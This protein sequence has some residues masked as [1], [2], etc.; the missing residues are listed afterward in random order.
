M[1]NILIGLFSFS[2]LS[3]ASYLDYIYDDRSAT[4][5]S[6]GQT[7]LIQTPSAETKGENGVY[8]VL[9]KND[10]YK[11]ATL[12]V[13]PFDWME[14]SYFYYQPRDFIWGGLKGKYLDKGFNVKINYKPGVRYLPDNIALGLDDF[15]GT[16]FFSREYIA[17]TYD[18]DWFKLSLGLG[19]GKYATD[20]SYKNPF[21]KIIS[22]LEN[23]PNPNLDIWEVG[24]PSFNQWFRGD[25]GLFGGIEAFIPRA[26]GL[27]FKIER[28]PFDYFDFSANFRSDSSPILRK[29]ESDINFG[30]SYP[31][32]DFITSEISFIKGNSINVSFVVGKTFKKSKRKKNFK[33]IVEKRY[34]D[35]DM[36]KEFYNNLLYNLNKDKLFLQ[37]ADLKKGHLN[38]S[39][40]DDNFNNAIVASSRAAYYAKQTAKLSSIQLNQIS[41]SGIL[42]GQEVYKVN[43]DANDINVPNKLPGSVIK[44]RII[45]NDPSSNEDYIN[46]EFQPLVKFPVFFNSIE[47][48]FRTHVG[49]PERFIYEGLG[50]S[51]QSEIQLSRSLILN[52][53]LGHSFDDDFDEKNPRPASD[54]PHVRTEIISY[55][56]ATDNYI[57]SAKFDYFWN[58]KPEMFFKLS[59]G[60]FEM[61]YAGYGLEYL[62]KPFEKNFLVGF[63]IYDVKRRTFEQKFEL[64]DYRVQTGHINFAYY[65]ENSG[66]TFKTSY[67]RYLAKDSGFTF[68]LSRK[69]NN[70][71]EAGFYFTLTDVPAELFGEGSFDKGFYFEIPFDLFQSKYSKNTFPFAYKPLTRDGGQ[72]LI[73][74]NDLISIYQDL[75]K[76]KIL[77]GSNEFLD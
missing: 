28:D 74:S 1:K 20:K 19:W 30:F 75:T 42:L 36:K 43:Y 59:G 49:S 51:F 67:G 63:E 54:L 7:G 29:K 24:R 3:E 52:L 48:D 64:L 2:I 40:D 66:I 37:T 73:N 5:N 32:N 60:I 65:F 9:N 13:S 33:P 61:M 35:P 14:A 17:G 46:H 26:R 71:F 39:I 69:S 45:I 44:Q 38:I 55:L 68:D 31:I 58:P 47:P 23:R 34:E 11:F 76:T 12:T 6:F 10:I 21:S 53:N 4:Y 16:G 56:Q 15:A 62:Y 72:K 18:F 77:E 25:I 27:K 57:T 50:L 70:G 22:Q 8:F 41:V